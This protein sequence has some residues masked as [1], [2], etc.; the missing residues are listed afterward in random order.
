MSEEKAKAPRLLVMVTWQVPEL[1]YFQH[2]PA[3]GHDSFLTST[4]TLT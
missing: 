2:L 4:H 3:L 1:H